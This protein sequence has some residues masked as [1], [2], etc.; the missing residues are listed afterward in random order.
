LKVVGYYDDGDEWMLVDAIV[1]RF[2]SARSLGPLVTFED[3]EAG[4]GLASRLSRRRLAPNSS[5]YAA[6]RTSTVPIGSASSGNTGDA[7]SPNSLIDCEED[8]TLRTVLVG[9]LRERG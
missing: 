6:S 4:S 9:M 8:G 5:T 3:I 1:D 2:K 7:P